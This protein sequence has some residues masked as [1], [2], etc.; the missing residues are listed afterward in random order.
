MT[1]ARLRLA[2]ICLSLST[3]PA[4]GHDYVVRFDVQSKHAT[5]AACAFA[6]PFSAESDDNLESVRSDG[7]SAWFGW[8]AAA[9]DTADGGSVI[10][11]SLFLAA[12]PDDTR[13]VLADRTYTKSFA[14][15]RGVDDFDASSGGD[16]FH[17]HVTGYAQDDDCGNLNVAPPPPPSK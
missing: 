13:E 17:V 1:A 7:R 8:R 6:G 5:A 10:D 12:T 3:L 9:D 11:A 4:C 16:T 15:D 2:I 14:L